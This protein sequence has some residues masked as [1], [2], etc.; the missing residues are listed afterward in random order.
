MTVVHIAHL[1]G[2]HNTGG[3]AI[4]A[5]RLHLAL[6]ESG[7]DSHFICVRACEE[8]LNVHVLPPCGTMA[9][10]MYIWLT[11]ALRG[12][13]R[14]TRIR[15]AVS[16]NLIP[17]FGLFKLLRMLKP[18][19]VHIHWIVSDVVSF[20]QLKKMSTPVVW[21]LHDL[22]AVN[23]LDPYPGA[24]SRFISGVSAI[25][26][27]LLER[28]LFARKRSAIKKL[29]P[30][31]IGP[32]NWICQ[33]AKKSLIGSDM[34]YHVVRNVIDPL[35]LYDKSLRSVNPRFQILFGA[36]GGRANKVK[37]WE[38]LKEAL[39]RLPKEV[40][41]N[42]R[43]SVFGEMAQDCV[44]NGVEIHFLGTICGA[45]N[46]RKVY[47]NADIFVLPSKLDN[48]PS[49]K[50][51]ALLCG[52]PVVA[53]DRAGCAEEIIQKVNG[54]IAQDGNSSGFATGIN[55]FYEQWRSLTGIPHEKIAAEAK[56]RYNSMTIVQEIVS[57]Y[58]EVRENHRNA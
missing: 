50:F 7:V 35:F 56:R 6:I 1:Y 21:T 48:A 11:K 29:S 55:F 38:D 22:F 10:R 4:A 31:F 16:L 46:L 45:E 15:R 13:W 36:Y 51:E 54:W 37:G 39:S 25:N 47:H 57:I 27:N 28:W 40:R 19:I 2:L 17:L 26:S 52:L 34:D 42:S 12:V 9:R 20:E 30:S 43:I 23:V 53:F 33:T 5:T 3:A 14:F 58:N 18:D 44:I 32:S 41:E 49:T 8:G 24:D